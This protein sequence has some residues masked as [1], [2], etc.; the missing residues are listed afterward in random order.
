MQQAVQLLIR[1]HG[2]K[3]IGY[4][5][6]WRKRGEVLSIFANLARKYDRLAVVLDDGVRSADERL[7][8]TVADLCIYSGKYLTWLAEQHP[9]A[10]DAISGH[11]KSVDCADVRGPGALNRVLRTLHGDAVDDV[12]TSWRRLKTAFQNLDDGL[13][14]QA[15][16]CTDEAT[17]T[18]EAKVELAWTVATASLI[19]LVALASDSPMEWAAWRAEIEALG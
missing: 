16:R 17:L 4:G 7:V 6:A 9:G 11:A 18:W 2:H 8:D 14:A 5:D 15:E 12:E 13:V 10:F 1:L 19:L 3:T